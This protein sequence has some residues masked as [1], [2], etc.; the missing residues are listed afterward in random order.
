MVY[1][2]R[3]I[4]RSISDALARDKSVLLF[5][6]RQTGKTTL[7]DKIPAD[8]KLS[9]IQPAVRQLYEKNPSLLTGRIEAL[10]SDK[11]ALPLV[12]IDEVQKVP[13]ILDVVQDL[14]DRKIAKFILTGSSARKLKTQHKLNLLPGRVIVLNLDPLTIDE[15]PETKKKL[16]DLLLFGALPG[17]INLTNNENREI[18]LRSYVTTYLEE[19]I[20]AEATVRN[21]ASFSKFLTLAAAESGN[22][23]NFSKLSQEI[24]VAHTTISAYYQ[25][26][27]DCLVA[28]KIEPFTQ[29]KFRR[30]LIKTP[31]YLF[32]DLGIRRLAAEE[33]TRPP[34][35]N[36]GML[37]EQFIGL[38][39]V[40]RTKLTYDKSKI[41]FWHDANGP[42][43][44]WVIAQNDQLIPIEVKWTDSPTINDA[45]HLK[46]FCSEYEN[47]SNSYV[48]CRVPHKI[49]LSEKIFALPWQDIGELIV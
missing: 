5:G 16:E 33:G 37:F 20:R 49:K 42:E 19:E 4:E 25:I 10:K 43:V 7:I 36:L 17:I 3:K 30:R 12:I 41:Y 47:T 28:E 21:V 8:A 22:L 18:D 40:R 32:F 6:A 15:L 27:E 23:V 1:I 13:E 44:D 9:F 46:S 35:K 29:T 48:I 34:L 45:K 38:E 31:K 26:L 2:K 24:G 11:N 14:I 39:L